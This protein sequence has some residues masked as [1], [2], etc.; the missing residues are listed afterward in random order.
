MTYLFIS[1]LGIYVAATVT[2]LA[3]F[4]T[5]QE[6]LRGLGRLL[7]IAAGL[8]HTC[9]LV[10][11][12]LQ[13]GHTPLTS[14]HDAVSFMA[15]AMTWGFLSF[16]YRYKVKNFGAFV[17]P[18]ITLLMVVATL[19]ST[20][21]RE[22]PPALQSGWL[23]VHASIALL[24]NSFLALAFC[25]GIMYLLLEGEIKK[26][27]FGLFCERLPSLEAL[28]NLNEHCLAVG[29]PLLTLGIITGSL[30]AKQAWGSYWHWDPKETWSLITWF[31]YAALLH[32]RFTMGWRRRRAA[33]MAIVGFAAALFTFWGVSFLLEGVHSYVG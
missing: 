24:A 23:P 3:Y 5:Q 14:N 27:R 16:R 13:A 18:L 29:F 2:A 17:T 25:G 15:W 22:L 7:L 6:K 32:Q 26:K 10:T 4:T 12:Y 33:I 28:D 19:S 30:W 9:Y 1:T 8:A 11:R 21:V 20:T 31:L